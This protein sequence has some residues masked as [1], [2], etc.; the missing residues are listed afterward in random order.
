MCILSLNNFFQIQQGQLPELNQGG[1][2]Q[3]TRVHDPHCISQEQDV[4]DTLVN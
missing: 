3:G 4:Q 2:G 1:T